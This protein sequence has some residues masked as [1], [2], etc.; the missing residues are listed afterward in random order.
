WRGHGKTAFAHIED[1]SGRLQLYFRKDALGEDAFALLELLDLGDWIGVEGA[2]F[3][4]RTGEVT[5]RVTG[6]TLLAKS[7]RP[8]PLGKTE[9]DA[10]TGEAVRHSAFTDTE[11]RYRQRYADL[12]VHREVREVFVRRA[13][14]VTA[15]RS[16]LDGEGFLE[17]ETPALQPLYGGATA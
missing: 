7:L 10:A 1:A 3:R 12:A 14:I 8:L 17:V 15:L 13:R 9:V 4:T 16:F 2:L 5:V 11:S 6:W